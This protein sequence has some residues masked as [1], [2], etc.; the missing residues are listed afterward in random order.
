MLLWKAADQ[1]CPP[2]EAMDIEH[3]GWSVNESTV[4]PASSTSLIVPQS[5]LD[6]VSCS[7]TAEVQACSTSR[8]SCNIA[9]LSCTNYCKC[10]GGVACFSHFTS[11]EHFPE[12]SNMNNYDFSDGG[13]VD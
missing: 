2:I 4:T 11:N 13:N 5:L 1:P 10:E 7:C 8:C 3:F 9:S 6:V 12:H